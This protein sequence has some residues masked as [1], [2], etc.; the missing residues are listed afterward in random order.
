M[1]NYLF[2]CSNCD[3]LKRC[4]FTVSE[5]QEKKEKITCEKCSSNMSRCFEKTFSF[6][7]DKTSQEIIEDIKR[8]KQKIIDKFNQ[9]DL[10]TITDICGE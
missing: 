5:F 3:E 8:D 4:N 10:K 7:I 2:K 9:G 1:P 6:K